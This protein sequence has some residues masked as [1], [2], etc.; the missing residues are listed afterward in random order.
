MI[1][2]YDFRLLLPE[3]TKSKRKTIFPILMLIKKI[4][5]LASY[6]SNI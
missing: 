2:N 6:Y 4:A 1:I 5:F 3:Q